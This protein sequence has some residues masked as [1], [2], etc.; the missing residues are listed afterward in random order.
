[1]RG[2]HVTVQAHRG[3]SRL[4]QRPLPSERGKEDVMKA[5]HRILFATDF[6]EASEPALAEAIEMAKGDGT[7]LLIA[8]VY[9]LP[10]PAQ[11]TS[12]ARGVYE[13]WTQN[14]RDRV[15]ERLAP[16][17]ERARAEGVNAESLVLNGT[18]YEAITQAA[19]FNG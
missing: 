15:E 9:Q 12:V 2:G 3:G 7:E 8:H 6:T 13:E 14:L 17:V 19:A 5:F 4:R 1:M 11:A 18:P 16:L 10:N